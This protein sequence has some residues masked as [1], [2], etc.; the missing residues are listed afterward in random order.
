[1]ENNL[2][3]K[4]SSG[5]KNNL[6]A[7]ETENEYRYA[8]FWIRLLASIIDSVLFVIVLGGLL[9]LLMGSDIQTAFLSVYDG[10]VTTI[11]EGLTQAQKYE[12]FFIN[13]ILPIFLVIFLWV[14]YGGTPGKLMLGIE[15]IDEKTGKNMSIGKSILRYIGYL[16][17]TIPLLL[18]FIWVAFD[19]RKRG[20]HDMI[21]GSVVVY[22]DK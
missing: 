2:K 7:E 10:S 11:E 4:S 18:G 20:F 5:V 16:L 13:N 12:Y 1:M 6:E 19:K 14:K 17:S 8:G 3:I 21:A 9:Y 15:V 22:K